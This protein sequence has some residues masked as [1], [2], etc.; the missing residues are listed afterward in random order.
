MKYDNLAQAASNSVG[1]DYSMWA[2]LSYLGRINYTLM[3]KY[4][5]SVSVRRDGSSKFADGHKFSTF[6]AMAIAWNL[7]NEE[8]IKKLNIFDKLKLRASWGLTGSQAISPYATLATYNTSV[9]YAFTTG[10]RTNGIQMGNPGNT[11]LKWET[12][13]QLDFGLELGFFNNR[14]NVE[15]DYFRSILVICC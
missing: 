5:F 12:T 2:L 15:L 4:L 3:D 6:P 1:S 11:D 13:E 9:Y 10:G 8:F 14:L 7:G